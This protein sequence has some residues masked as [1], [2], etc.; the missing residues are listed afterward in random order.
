MD[1]LQE[2]LAGAFDKNPEMMKAFE[3]M[4][5]DVMKM[6]EQMSSMS[7]DELQSQMEEAMKMM[8]SGNILE[9]IVDKKDEVL[10][11]LEATGLV[12]KEEIAKYKADPV[13]F[14]EQMKGAFDQ[15]KGIFSDPDLM[16]TAADAMTGFQKAATNPLLV[17]LQDLLMRKTTPS[18]LEIEEMRLKMIQNKENTDDSIMATLFGAGD[19]AEKIASSKGWKE[20]VMEGRAAIAS[21]GDLG[22]GGMAGMGAGAG[23]GEL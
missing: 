18:D 3:N 6:M 1:A 15:M 19:F 22:L 12:S 21:M 13:Y 23:V 5:E 2:L 16:K 8:T 4:G 10:A 9:S 11:N 7:P 17:D 14:E 20:S